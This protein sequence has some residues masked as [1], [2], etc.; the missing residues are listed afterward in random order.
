VV[1][2]PLAAA[3]S[4]TAF[5]DEVVGTETVGAN[6]DSSRILRVRSALGA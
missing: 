1:A 5:E 3:A 2:A 6:A 4:A